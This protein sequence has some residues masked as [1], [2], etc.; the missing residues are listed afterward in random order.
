MRHYGEDNYIN[1]D[2]Y[3]NDYIKQI[4]VVT[5]RIDD[6]KA[7]KL[8]DFRRLNFASEAIEFHWG[9]GYDNVTPKSLL[10][11]RRSSDDGSSLWK[12][13]NVVQENLIKGKV[14][15]YNSESGRRLKTRGV[16]NLR[17]SMELNKFLWQLA[18]KYL[19][20]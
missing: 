15:G 20:N 8:T 18:E 5:D 6:F 7:K 3:L 17:S 19:N 2:M 1:F 9:R 12:T 16:T 10:S 4:P 14:D 13:Y 11:P